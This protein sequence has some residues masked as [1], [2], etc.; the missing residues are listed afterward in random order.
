MDVDPDSSGSVLLEEMLEDVIYEEE[1]MVESV[2]SNEATYLDAEI[3]I[4]DENVEVIADEV[5]AVN[6]G[7]SPAST[8]DESDSSSSNDSSSTSNNESDSDDNEEEDSIINGIN[9]QSN[10]GP[11]VM[12]QMVEEETVTFGTDN[13]SHDSAECTAIEM[14]ADIIAGGESDVMEHVDVIDTNVITTELTTTTSAPL[15]TTFVIS[16]GNNLASQPLVQAKTSQN[17]IVFVKLVSS[18]NT[19]IMTPFSSTSTVSTAKIVDNCSVRLTTD[20]GK[21]AEAVPLT[22][23]VATESKS[24]SPPIELPERN[25]AC[26]TLSTTTEEASTTVTTTTVPMLIIKPVASQTIERTVNLL[27]NNKILIKSVKSTK[28]PSPPTRSPTTAENSEATAVKSLEDSNDIKTPKLDIDDIE[29]QQQKPMQHEMVGTNDVTVN[30]TT[31]IAA[32]DSVEVKP[33]RLA[34]EPRIKESL[35]PTDNVVKEKVTTKIKREFEQLQKTVNESK[36]LMEYVT[37]KKARGRRAKKS[38]RSTQS[39]IDL[40]DTDSIASKSSSICGLSRS[41]STSRNESPIMG[42][43][44]ISKESDRSVASGGNRNMRSLN[45]EFTAKQQKFLQNLHKNHES[46][47]ESDVSAKDGDESIDYFDDGNENSREARGNSRNDNSMDLELAPKVYRRI[48][49]N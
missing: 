2:P 49:I 33:E 35:L 40:D 32:A 23:T 7:K 38:I 48:G 1:V 3:E 6:G 16:G 39:T 24:R 27:N 14:E 31:V 17:K 26:S 9:P 10:D 25:G 4:S 13:M 44:S 11:A 46:G 22:P 5:V 21:V 37:D 8:S 29:Q 15:K 42:R 30:T 45:A 34:D 47:D 12:E 36:V 28:N 41:R 19:A 43:R 20:V 18:A